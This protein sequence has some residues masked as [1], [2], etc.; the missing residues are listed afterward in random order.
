MI[1][2]DYVIKIAKGTEDGIWPR[3]CFFLPTK[4]GP[5]D[6]QTEQ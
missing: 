6:R 4:G 2:N 3:L 1:Q 5:M